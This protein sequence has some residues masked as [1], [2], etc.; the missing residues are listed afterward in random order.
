MRDKIDKL[1]DK[2]KA[3]VTKIQKDYDK[4]ILNEKNKLE[5]QL[6]QV[7]KKN[8]EIVENENLRFSKMVEELKTSHETKIAE[9]QI[10]HDKEI[11]KRENDHKD[12]LDTAQQKFENEKNK[13]EA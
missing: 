2:S 12:Y 10:S 1:S 9:L 4:E 11:E 8:K 5:A 3:T 7:R 6:I 13:L